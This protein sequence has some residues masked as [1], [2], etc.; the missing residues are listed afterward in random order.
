MNVDHWEEF[1]HKKTQKM[2]IRWKSVV[3]QGHFSRYICNIRT[4][5]YMGDKQGHG[6]SRLWEGMESQ[7]EGQP[8]KEDIKVQC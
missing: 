2:V 4:R 3:K 6:H 1:D 7:A 8:L 5:T